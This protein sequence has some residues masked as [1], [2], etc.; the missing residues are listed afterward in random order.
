MIVFFVYMAVMLAFSLLMIISTWIVF[1]KAGQPGW[2]AIIPIFNMILMLKVANRP[3]WW[4]ILFIIPIV[5]IVVAIIMMV[6]IARNFGH[7]AGFAIGLIFLPFIFWP[8]LAFG[9]SQY[10]P[11]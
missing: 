6:D 1:N 4:I 7:G 9:K 5:S 10:Q 2:G 3:I 11:A 8:I